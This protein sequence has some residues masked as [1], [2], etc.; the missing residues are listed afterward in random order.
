MLLASRPRVLLVDS[1]DQS[2]MYAL[3]LRR[4]GYHV[5]TAMDCDEA[6]AIARAELPKVIV[7]S[8]RLRGDSRWDACRQLRTDAITGHIPIILLTASP[9]DVTEEAAR[10]VGATELLLKPCLPDD[11]V[12]AVKRHEAEALLEPRVPATAKRRR[13]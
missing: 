4:H 3:A 5:L 9:F 7:L 10:E 6:V 11:L 2:E 1:P 8:M 13:R 12:T